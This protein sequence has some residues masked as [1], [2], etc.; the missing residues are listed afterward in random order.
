MDQKSTKT[1]GA[2]AWMAKNH[3]TANLLMMIFLLGGL[4][5]TSRIKQEIFPDLELDYI[6]ITVP[7]PG[8]S[9]EEVEEGVVLAIEEELRGL[10]VA[11]EVGSVC[12]EGFG[13]VTVELQ[14][15]SDP[16]KA[17][18]DV[19]NAVDRIRTFPQE[20][21]RYT[22]NLVENRRH[23]ISIMV[24]GDQSEAA[25]R[26][27]AEKIR[28]DLLKQENI[29]QIDLSGIRRPEIA[30][31][32]SQEQ[33]RRYNL[34]LEQVA[35]RIRTAALDLPGGR[36]KT[37]AGEVLVRTTERRYLGREY[38]ELPI[39]VDNDGTMIA[40]GEI[41]HVRDDFEE[42]DV[43][44]MYNGER[45]VRIDIYRVGKETPTDVSSAVKVYIDEANSKLPPTV[46]LSVWEDRAELLEDRIDLLVNNALLG[47]MLVILLLGLSL[48]IRLA[49]WV[50][51]GIPISILGALFF[52]PVTDLSINMVSLFAIII[53]IGIVVDDAVIIGENIHHQRNKHATYLEA[54][55]AG[56][57]EMALP[58]T[59]S[60]LTNILAFVPMFFV[61]GAMGKIFKVI[62]LA[63]IMIFMISLIEALFILPAHLS[64][65][66]KVE[67]A[68]LIYWANK[69]REWFGNMLFWFRD[70]PFRKLL[71]LALNYRYIALAL[72]ITL[73]M[74]SIGVVASGRMDFSFM[75]KI[76]AERITAMVEMPFGTP[77][78]ETKKVQSRLLE[79]AHEVIEE[80][81]GNNITLGIY[82]LVGAPLT[83]ED[84]VMFEVGTDLSGAHLTSVSVQLVPMDERTI[85]AEEFA[86]RWKKKL[87]R[88]P[89]V[90]TLLFRFTTGPSSNQPI[91]LMIS[92]PQIE[93]LEHAA[94]DLA[95]VLQGY[96]GVRDVDD[97]Y[98]SGKVQLDF[99]I[100]PEA[101]SMGINAAGLARQVRSAFYGA[102]ALRVQ[103][104]RDEVKVLVRLPEEERQ[105]RYNIEELIIRTPSGSEIPIREAAEVIHNRSYTEIIRSNGR[106]VLNITADVETDIAN[107]SKVL[108]SVEENDLPG[109]FKKYSGLKM[110]LDGEQQEQNESMAALR[111]G[112]IMA[113][114]AIYALLAIPFKNYAQPL[115]IMISIPFGIIGAII[116]HLIMGYELS[117][118]SM[119]GIIALAGVVVNDSLILVNTA[120]RNQWGGMSHYDSI[121]NASIRRF[122]PILLTS[123]TTFLGL[124]PMIFET[125]LQARFMIPMAISLGFGILFATG[126]AL[127]VVPCFYL[128]LV[129]IK[130]LLGIREAEV[131]L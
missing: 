104:G 55:I 41:A 54:S 80:N 62:P 48:D 52:F 8:A 46:R 97:G 73:L 33:L 13:Q 91:N 12:R 27:L 44:A 110:E 74:L 4:L 108:D 15:G 17:L 102:E 16:N 64:R 6:F 65:R 69:R 51:L 88:I 72:A 34:T 66:S 99:R 89:G 117:I 129:D 24:H 78:E 127:I 123:L 86:K 70:N 122:R 56:A 31:E 20:M 22:V 39:I 23:V 14:L 68:G 53:T 118:I 94:T 30:I 57:R 111:F 59:F 10:D 130:N 77:I 120:N 82:T 84:M 60:I 40:L 29:T 124:A 90:E 47:L 103:R 3:V 67:D 26:N 42:T 45:A 79:T 128:V 50:T 76:E 93:V 125:S 106:R 1:T 21:E 95:E 25:L 9:P 5:M 116:G 92:H 28:E 114:F 101:Q 71:T 119:F 85:S 35:T 96:A 112:F 87:G 126:I 100:K 83:G 107:A 98:S 81:G 115:I 19:K 43:E 109:L 11:K 121:F 61:P 18:S 58:I 7:Y 49:F 113:L 63:V 32:I 37:P 105:S 2:I 36:V 131:N 38:E 75:P